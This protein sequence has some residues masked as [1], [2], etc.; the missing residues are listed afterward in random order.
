[1]IN[2]IISKKNFDDFVLLCSLK[3]EQMD[4]GYMLV[5]TAKHNEIKS[6]KYLQ[7]RLISCKEDVVLQ[8]ALE[9]AIKSKSFDTTLELMRQKIRL[10]KST[11]KHLLEILH[12]QEYEQFYRKISG[13][14]SMMLPLYSKK[15]I[16][17][18]RKM[19]KKIF[20]F[21]EYYVDDGSFIYEYLYTIVH[22]SL[23]DIYNQNIIEDFDLSLESNQAH[24]ITFSKCYP[25]DFLKIFESVLYKNGFSSWANDLLA[26]ADFENKEIKKGVYNIE[27]IIN[28]FLSQGRVD[29]Y[30]FINIDIK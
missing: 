24:I 7:N 23:V 30:S 19:Y 12:T 8:N 5:S 15:N 9:Y 18:K 1:M 13:N 2:F 25:I 21:L 14:S 22:N 17:K 27:R 16:L 11:Q 6:L 10:E 29:I 20:S 3:D 28:K 4:Y 26:L